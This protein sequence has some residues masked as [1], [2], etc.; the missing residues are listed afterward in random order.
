LNFSQSPFFIFK[1]NMLKEFL[2]DY[3]QI[4]SFNF[5]FK[6]EFEIPNTLLFD[7]KKE[8]GL[9]NS[10]AVMKFEE[11]KSSETKQKI[12]IEEEG[13]RSVQDLAMRIEDAQSVEGL[14][15]PFIDFRTSGV[16]LC[17][18][19]QNNKALYINEKGESE[20]VSLEFEFDRP[21][22]SKAIVFKNFASCTAIERNK[23]LYTGG[24]PSNEAFLLEFKSKKKAHVTCLPKMNFKRCWH[25]TVYVRPYVYVIGGYDGGSRL[26]DCERLNIQDNNHGA[27]FESITP[28][29]E[30]RS[31]FGYTLCKNNIIYVVGGVTASK[32]FG[33]T[34]SIE[35][36]S[37]LENKWSMLN[38]RIPSKLCGLSCIP[39]EDE[40]EE[41]IIMFGGSDN[42]NRSVKSVL[43]LN[44]T[45]GKINE[46]DQMVSKRQMN[47]KAFEKHGIVYLIGGNTDNDCE[48]WNFNNSSKTTFS[49]GDHIK[50]DLKNFCAFTA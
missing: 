29:N 27:N 43:E 41:K 1:E 4:V 34:D 15:D 45:E 25:G 6:N 39:L 24:G 7:S 28:L 10:S 37:V 12:E 9:K 44:L 49:Y 2:E 33:C 5:G 31:L 47:N 32:K 19:G 22:D 30:A 8:L 35:K 48:V 26:K 21:E 18:T 11:F 20:L 14:E 38:I 46:F 36:Y 42:L 40:N 50:S 23:V 17:L 13:P 3:A 16:T